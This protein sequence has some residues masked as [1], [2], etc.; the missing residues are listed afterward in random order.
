MRSMK[1]EINAIL[2]HPD[3]NVVTVTESLYVGN[4]AR[5]E[6]DGGVV[7]IIV[8]DDIPEYHKIAIADFKIADPVYKYGQLIG[9]ATKAI[10]KGSHV[11]DHNIAS[12][13]RV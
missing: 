10:D 13:K 11:H 7:S 9:E 8:K 12:I 1:R 5:Y 3:D 4:V 6:K 2:I